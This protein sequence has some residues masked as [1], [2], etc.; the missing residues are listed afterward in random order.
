MKKNDFIKE[1]RKSIEVFKHFD[2]RDMAKIEKEWFEAELQDLHYYFNKRC[3]DMKW[4]Y[5]NF[6]TA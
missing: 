2:T 1:T 4:R 5:K 3:E 6:L